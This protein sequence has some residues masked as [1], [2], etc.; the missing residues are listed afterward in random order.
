MY[1]MSVKKKDILIVDDSEL[2]AERLS[3]LLQ[4]QESV[5]FVSKAYN[6]ESAFRQLE[7]RNPQV[8]ILDINLG[9]VNG[10]QLLSMIKE[11]Y[12]DKIVMMFTN[13]AN[14]YY[15]TLCKKAGAD[16][17]LDKSKDFE[18]IPDIIDSLD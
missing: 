1:L 9:S 14:P 10:I 18:L 11:K 6:H 7:Q 8:V 15:R 17:F 16:Y 3:L 12:P 4:E 13:H 5:G 2:I